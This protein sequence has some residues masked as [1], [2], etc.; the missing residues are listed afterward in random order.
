MVKNNTFSLS[1]YILKEAP[2]IFFRFFCKPM[3]GAH[4]K[5]DSFKGLIRFH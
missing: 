2:S 3:K 1:E 5:D 4:K